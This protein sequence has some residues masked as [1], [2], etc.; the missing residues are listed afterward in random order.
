MDLLAAANKYELLGL[1]RFSEESLANRIN[2]ENVFNLYRIADIT[3]AHYLS[4]QCVRFLSEKRWNETLV[5]SQNSLF[6][7]SPASL[8][9]LLNEILT[10]KDVSHET[11]VQTNAK[12]SIRRD[13]RCKICND[14]SQFTAGT[15]H[16]GT[17]ISHLKR[18]HAMSLSNYVHLYK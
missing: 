16:Y 8:V 1:K 17:F 2:E 14:G 13:I 11:N 4:K 7:E 3:Q 9:K 6:L 15:R 12:D 10:T 18:T 5:N